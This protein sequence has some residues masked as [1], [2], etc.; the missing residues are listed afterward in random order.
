[1]GLIPLLLICTYRRF[2]DYTDYF[3]N[4]IQMTL[5]N[6]WIPLGGFESHRGQNSFFTIYSIREVECEKLFCKTNLKLKSIKIKNKFN[7]K[8]LTT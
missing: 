2:T 5:H 8:S 4:V 7:S 6:I 1:M 3:T